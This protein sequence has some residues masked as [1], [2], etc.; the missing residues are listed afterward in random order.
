M[1]FATVIDDY[2]CPHCGANS[3]YWWQEHETEDTIEV[4]MNCNDE[5]GCGYEFPKMVVSKSE[6]TSRTAL[7]ERLVDRYL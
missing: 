1:G 2:D 5:D 6:D 4:Y 7:F 3:L